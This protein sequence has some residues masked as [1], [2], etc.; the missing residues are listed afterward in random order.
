MRSEA[1]LL[2]DP[3]EISAVFPPPPPPVVM[4]E[5]VKRYA[6]TTYGFARYHYL[7]RK[8]PSSTVS[9][10]L[11]RLNGDPMGMVVLATI[12]STMP[13][14]NLGRNSA[15]LVVLPDFG[16]L[17]YGHHC[18]D[19]ALDL[20]ASLHAPFRAVMTSLTILPSIIRGYRREPSRWYSREPQGKTVLRNCLHS[21][22]RSNPTRYYRLT[23][24]KRHSFHFIGIGAPRFDRAYAIRL[25]GSQAEVAELTSGGS[26]GTD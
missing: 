18:Q 8:L 14:Y 16:G 12:A 13:E 23:S 9:C 24:F 19:Y 5:R 17:N 3:A 26:H 2:T 25:I 22:L 1:R 15:R 21:R 10:L 6:W 11:F 7:T 4:V 20:V